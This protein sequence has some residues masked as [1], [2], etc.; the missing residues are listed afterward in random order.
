VSP[1][2][3]MYAGHGSVR[4][5]G[6]VTFEDMTVNLPVVVS[7]RDQAKNGKSKTRKRRAL[8]RAR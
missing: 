7:K 1:I 5:P 3:D 4:T 6:A 2:S 8:R